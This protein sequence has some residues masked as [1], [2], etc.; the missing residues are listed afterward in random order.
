M[1]HANSEGGPI[2]VAD[3]DAFARWRGASEDWGDDA[4]YRVHWYGPLVGRLPPELRR[5]EGEWHQEAVMSGAKA[6]S[7]F[8]DCLR[9]A[10]LG[11][12]AKLTERAQQPMSLEQMLAKARAA[13]ETP[14]TWLTAWRDHVE[15]GFDLSLGEEVMLHI[16][17]RPDTEYARACAALQ[18]DAAML[19]ASSLAWELEGAGIADVARANDGGFLLMRSWLDEAGEREREARDHAAAPPAE[20]EEEV[21]TLTFPTGRVAVVWAPIEATAV[22]RKAAHENLAEVLRQACD[23]APPV[24]LNQTGMLNVG[25]LLNIPPGEYRVTCGSHEEDEWSCR[26]IRFFR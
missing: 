18:G 10:A 22:V 16:D 21:G 19:G 17:A 7:D 2:L 4:T 8:T 24:Q 25:S 6:A 26:W 5:A 12:E 9:A 11:L 3:L 1:G 14:A 23:L 20:E 13:T 15:Q